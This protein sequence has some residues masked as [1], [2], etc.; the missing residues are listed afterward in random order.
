MIRIDVGGGNNPQPGFL[1][2]DLDNPRADIQA[3]MG[4]LPFPDASVDVIFSSHALEHVSKFEVV[5]VLREWRRVMKP[6]GRIIIRVPNLVWCVKRWLQTQG[7]GWDMALI[8]GSQ[9]Q[10]GQTIHQGEFHKTGFTEALMRK[11]LQQARLTVVKYEVLW[12]HEQETM[13]FECVKD[14]VQ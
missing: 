11:Y 12:T 8:F 10:D 1:N 5:P 7:D 2:V 9:S 4:K 6:S 3:D 13:S 14:G